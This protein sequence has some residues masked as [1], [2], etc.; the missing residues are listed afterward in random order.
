MINPM[1]EQASIRNKLHDTALDAPKTS[2]VYLWKDETG[3]VI[4]VGKAK[5]LKNRLSSYFTSNR[6]IKTRILVSRAYSIEYITTENEYEALLLENT[7][8]KKYSPRYNI[9]LKD[10]KTYPVIKITGEKFPR[11]Y[12]TRRIQ[13]DGGRYFGPF[14]DV[15][16]ADNFLD[17][18]KRNYKLRQCRVLKK[19]TTPCLYYHIGRCSAPCCG[20]FPPRT[21]TKSSTRSSCSSTGT[22]RLLSK[23][24]RCP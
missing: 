6:D 17:F 4:Y 20:K 11:M 2:G 5:S 21:T 24:S 3:L 13:N 18:I 14:P 9:N 16:A 15:N 7:L 10:G 8:I 22:R 12:R 1:K 23:N 19:R